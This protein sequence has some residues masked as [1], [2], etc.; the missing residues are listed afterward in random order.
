MSP[1]LGLHGNIQNDGTH[2]QH[3]QGFENHI[4]NEPLMGFDGGSGDG[5]DAKHH[6]MGASDL[7]IPSGYSYATVDN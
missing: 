5:N 2:L 1:N 4:V 3:V 6:L 7:G